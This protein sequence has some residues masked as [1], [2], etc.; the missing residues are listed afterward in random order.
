MESK[1]KVTAAESG[2][3]LDV[4][5]A[6]KLE[7]SRNQIQQLIRAGLATVNGVSTKASYEVQRGDELTVQLLASEQPTFTVPELKVVYEDEDLLVVDKPAGLVVHQARGKPEP[8]VA[9]F[10]RLHSEDADPERPGIVHRLDRDTSGLLIIAKTVKAKAYLQRLFR[11]HEVTKTYLALVE[12]RLDPPA[13]VINLPL[14]RSQS[15]PTQQ[16]V[17]SGGKPAV[18]AY[19]VIKYYPGATLVEAKPTTGRTHQLRVHFA[20]LHHPIVGDKVYGGPWPPH[21]KRQFLHAAGL[22]F[23]SLSGRHLTLTSPLPP[24]LTKYQ[25]ELG[26]L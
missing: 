10:S 2:R 19:R 9:D 23:T 17:H 18:T 22:S 11:R 14:T 5:L 24:D 16:T 26:E 3:R 20:H 8:S 1:F 12:G 15:K 4:V 25:Q 7:Q 6:Q 13:A 21:L